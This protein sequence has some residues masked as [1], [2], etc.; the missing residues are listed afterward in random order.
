MYI[1]SI[2][3]NANKAANDLSSHI[4]DLIFKFGVKIAR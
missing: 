4:A 1:F 3:R 2:A